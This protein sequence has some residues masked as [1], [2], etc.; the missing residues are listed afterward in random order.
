MCVVEGR[1]RVRL[2]LD[3]AEKEAYIFEEP[4]LLAGHIHR[5]DANQHGRHVAARFGSPLPAHAAMPSFAR[6]DEASVATMVLAKKFV[7]AGQLLSIWG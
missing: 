7:D 3:R 6:F 1:Q 5:I 2:E 4:A